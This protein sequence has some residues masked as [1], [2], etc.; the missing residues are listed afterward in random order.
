M[1]QCAKKKNSLEKTLEKYKQDHTMTLFSTCIKYPQMGW[2]A[3]KMNEWI[4][5][6]FYLVNFVFLCSYIFKVIN[7]K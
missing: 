5:Q 2:P 1:R 3:V 7:F 4:N 6:S